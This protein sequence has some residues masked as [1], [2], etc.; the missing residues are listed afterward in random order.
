M[1]VFKVK[2]L[3]I[4]LIRRSLFIPFPW[5]RKAAADSRRDGL[6]EE[7]EELERKNENKLDGEGEI[8]MR[9]EGKESMD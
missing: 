9:E 8:D 6:E 1:R 4:Y 2:G 3:C 7:E 5:E